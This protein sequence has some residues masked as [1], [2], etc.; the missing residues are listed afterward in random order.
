MRT[1]SQHAML[2]AALVDFVLDLDEGVVRAV[3]KAATLPFE[4]QSW[5][6]RCKFPGTEE[7][8]LSNTPTGELTPADL[9][10]MK[11]LG[12]PSW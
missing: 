10:R 7:Y 12:G 8:R 5:D 11:K 9:K 1:P 4:K 3:L 2:R 6:V